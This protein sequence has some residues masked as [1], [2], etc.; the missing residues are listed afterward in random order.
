M[1]GDKLAGLAPGGT[2]RQGFGWCPGE[3]AAPHE[4]RDRAP[5]PDRDRPGLSESNCK[6]MR[7]ARFKLAPRRWA[8]LHGFAPADADD[9]RPSAPYV[10]SLGRW[11]SQVA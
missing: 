6:L 4:A 11:A 3:A 9:Q 2:V 1:A 5:S 10:R 7:E 8:V